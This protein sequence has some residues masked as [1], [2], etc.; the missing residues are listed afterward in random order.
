MPEYIDAEI[1]GLRDSTSDDEITVLLG[2]SGDRDEFASRV[3]DEGG[4]VEARLGQ[5]TLLVS[6]SESAIDDLC[7][8]QDLKSLEIERDDVRMLDEGDE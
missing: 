4:S 1:E 7:E 8:L 2:I 3:V 5:A 6:A